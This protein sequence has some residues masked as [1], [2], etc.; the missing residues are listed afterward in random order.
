MRSF[1]TGTE[2]VPVETGYSA[3]RFMVPTE[4]VQKNFEAAALL[5]RTR[6]WWSVFTAPSR[7]LIWYECKG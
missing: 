7:G 5:G 1:V 6:G 4:K 3:Y 2:T